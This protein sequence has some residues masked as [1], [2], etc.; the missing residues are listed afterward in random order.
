MYRDDIVEDRLVTPGRETR[1]IPIKTSDK[2]DG[3]GQWL[4]PEKI[5]ESPH[6]PNCTCIVTAHNPAPAYRRF[7]TFKTGA[8]PRVRRARPSSFLQVQLVHP[9]DHRLPNFQTTDFLPTVF[10]PARPRED[11]PRRRAKMNTM[12]NFFARKKLRVIARRLGF[13]LCGGHFRLYHVK[14]YL[15]DKRAQF[16]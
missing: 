7:S 14:W 3:C 15:V 10:I 11:F 5:C 12:R 16:Y 8:V 9:V 13:C 4:W 2:I 6:G 1:R